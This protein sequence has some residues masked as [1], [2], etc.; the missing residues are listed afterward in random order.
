MHRTVHN[1]WEK[2][3][4]G[5]WM[6]TVQIHIVQELAVYVPGTCARAEAAETLGQ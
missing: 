2:K 6:C 5:V 4:V 1:Y 3:S